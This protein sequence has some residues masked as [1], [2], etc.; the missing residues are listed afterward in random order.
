[1][2]WWIALAVVVIL[3]WLPLGVNLLYNENGL[4]AGVRAAF[5][6]IPVYPVAKKEKKPEKEKPAKTQEEQINES[7]PPQPPKEKGGSLEKLKQYLPFVRIALDFL[8]DFRR[9]LRI[10][11]LDLKVIMAGNDPCSLAENYGRAWAALGN[12]L[13]NLERYFVIKKRNLEVE[14]DFTGSKTLINARVDLRITLGRLLGLAAVYGVRALREFLI[15][16]KKEKA[17]HNY[18]TE[19]SQYAGNDHSENS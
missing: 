8:G 12:L 6:T 11:R 14:C 15:L 18:D 4:R 5:V 1:M 16:K 7:K 17:V 9:K 2:G 10:N 3:A 19:T 13:P